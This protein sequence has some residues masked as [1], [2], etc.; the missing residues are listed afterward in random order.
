MLFFT[1][2][3]YKAD[4]ISMPSNANTKDKS[5]I[6]N[7]VLYKTNIHIGIYIPPDRDVNIKNK[8]NISIGLLIILLLKI[9]SIPICFVNVSRYR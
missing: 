6:T 3:I 5:L 4:D 2:T 1:L 8:K 9:Y 7:A